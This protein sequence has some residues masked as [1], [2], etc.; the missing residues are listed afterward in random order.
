MTGLPGGVRAMEGL[1]RHVIGIFRAPQHEQRV[2][3][4]I[5][6]ALPVECLE[7]FVHGLHRASIT[8][9][10]EHLFGPSLG[11]HQLHHTGIDEADE[12]SVPRDPAI[13]RQGR[14]AVRG[15]TGRPVD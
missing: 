9:S 1:A 7:R 5:P 11:V 4:D 12:R 6:V 14:G 8:N 13:F 10:L 3:I 15:P 2:A